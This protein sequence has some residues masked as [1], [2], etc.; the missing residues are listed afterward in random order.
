MI[1]YRCYVVIKCVYKSAFSLIFAHYNVSNIN[2]M[3]SVF[4]SKESQMPQS[5][6]HA[7]SCLI[8]VTKQFLDIFICS[9]CS[10][11]FVRCFLDIYKAMLKLTNSFCRYS[12]V[13]CENIN[14]NNSVVKH[15]THF[16]CRRKTCI[17]S[18]SQQ[19]LL[20]PILPTGGQW[21]LLS[22]IKKRFRLKKSQINFNAT[23]AHKQMSDPMKSSLNHVSYGGRFDM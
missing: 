3:F 15:I 10:Y 16:S 4:Y 12:R 20:N 13:A 1:G 9:Q 2:Y 17:T 22:N 18:N 7:T 23:K 21:R 19:S 6:F 8:F 5:K 11:I 14:Y